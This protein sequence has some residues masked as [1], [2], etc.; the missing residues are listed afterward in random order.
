MRLK[1]LRFNKK[2][3]RFFVK[4]KFRINKVLIYSNLK[5]N[6]PKYTDIIPTIKL[7]NKYAKKVKI[8]PFWINWRLSFENDENVVKPP[9]R[10]TVK[11]TNNIEFGFS[12]LM[13]YPKT[14]PSIKQP[15]KFDMNVEYGKLL[16]D[17]I[18]ILLTRNLNTL[19]KP[20]PIKTA[21]ISLSIYKFF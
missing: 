17:T 7:P 10:P 8:S 14:K 11:N 16:S 15:K 1:K 4:S 12:F 19:P 13:K 9:Q 2:Q 5:I 6:V 3:Y 20:P 21:I 18:S